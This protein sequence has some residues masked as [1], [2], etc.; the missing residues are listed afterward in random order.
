MVC[1]GNGEGICYV[2][3]HIFK[4]ITLIWEACVCPKGEFD[5][6]HRLECLMG[7]CNM[8]GFHLLNIC[9]FK[10]CASNSFTL[11]WKCFEYYQVGVDA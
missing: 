5:V 10:L 9:L 1:L 3:E 7:D 8:C 2:H 6:W 11:K 4:W